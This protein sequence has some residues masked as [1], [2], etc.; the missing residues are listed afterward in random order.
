M[1]KTQRRIVQAAAAACVAAI[2][3][4]VLETRSVWG[5]SPAPSADERI[6]HREGSVYDHK[7]HQPTQGE[8]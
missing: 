2:L 5:Q 1:T 4:P 8:V 6:P 3:A 7:R